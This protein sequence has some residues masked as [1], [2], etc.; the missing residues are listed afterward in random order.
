MDRPVRQHPSL[1]TQQ[2]VNRVLAHLNKP[3]TE[4]N[5]W[6]ARTARPGRPRSPS[7]AR[8][9]GRPGTAHQAALG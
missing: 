6:P 2:R 5:T 4:G 3:I 1:E 9:I 7:D 8:R